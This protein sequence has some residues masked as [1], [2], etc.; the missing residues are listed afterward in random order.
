MGQG[1]HLR[2]T[3]WAESRERRREGDRHVEGDDGPGEQRERRE[4]P[5]GEGKGGV[6]HQVDALW[7]GHR[8]AEE[9]VGEAALEGVAGT[10]GPHVGEEGHGRCEVGG[11]REGGRQRPSRT[12]CTVP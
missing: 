1:A 11:A 7:G 12:A 10:T 2:V 8:R 5:P 9:R 3:R 4:Q 6:G